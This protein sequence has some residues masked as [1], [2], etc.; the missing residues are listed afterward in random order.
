MEKSFEEEIKLSKDCVDATRGYVFG[1]HV[2]NHPENIY[3]EF[4]CCA[5]PMAL[6][7]FIFMNICISNSLDSFK[8]SHIF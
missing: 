3:I 4:W 5:L 7:E 2:F 8:F 6:S 1:E